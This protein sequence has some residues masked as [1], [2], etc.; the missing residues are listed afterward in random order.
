MSE[1]IDWAAVMTP[2]ERSV[3]YEADRAK[4]HW[5]HLAPQRTAIINRC[6]QRAKYRRR[7]ADADTA[8][9][10]PGPRDD[11]YLPLPPQE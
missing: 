6:I 4:A 11:P 7:I 9:R 1:P 3:V 2:E 10:Q 5:L 8:E